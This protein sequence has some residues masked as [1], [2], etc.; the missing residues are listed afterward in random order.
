[1]YNC[2]KHE[3]KLQHVILLLDTVFKLLINM[4]ETSES[5]PD[6]ETEANPTVDYSD[7]SD[8]EDIRN[9]IDGL[10]IPKISKKEDD[11]DE[12]LAQMEDPNYWRTVIDP[13]T[14]GKVVLGDDAIDVIQNIQ[15]ARYPNSD[16][17]PY[18]RYVDFFTGETATMP[19]KKC[20]SLLNQ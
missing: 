20:V 12:F 13:Q 5:V 4:K 16:Y 2:R 11:I 1:M 7:S 17:D 14:G 10:R 9:T 8:E 6:V 15:K 19:N 18:P 3:K